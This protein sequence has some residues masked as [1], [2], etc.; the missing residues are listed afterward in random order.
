MATWAEVQHHLRKKYASQISADNPNLMALDFPCSGQRAQRILL[1]TFEAVGKGW[2][3]FRSRVCE[4]ARIDPE[5]AL[6]RNAGFAVGFLAISED[7]YEL[8]YTAQ[9][10]TLDLDELELPLHVI[11]DTA[12]QLER[13]FTGGDN[14]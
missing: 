1:S 6:R 12:D 4:R 14:W 2:V 11:T 13:E 8:V 3:L 10:N 9:L 5:E 7:H